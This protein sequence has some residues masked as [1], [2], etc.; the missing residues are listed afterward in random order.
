MKRR[1]HP[2]ARPRPAPSRES[3]DERQDGGLV[4]V[5]FTKR[6]QAVIPLRVD[7]A[8][9]HHVALAQL[10]DGGQQ[11]RPDP[12]L[13]PHL[14]GG[15]LVD[16]LHLPASRPAQEVEHPAA[17]EHL[18]LP[19]LLEGGD[20]E[21]RE[22]ADDHQHD[23]RASPSAC[24]TGS[25][26]WSTAKENRPHASSAR[27]TRRRLSSWSHAARSKESPG[28]EAA[29]RAGARRRCHRGLP[30]HGVS[31]CGEARGGE[32]PCDPSFSLGRLAGHLT[33]SRSPRASTV[34]VTRH[35]PSDE[36]VADAPSPHGSRR[37]AR[38]LQRTC[39]PSA[40]LGIGAHARLVGHLRHRG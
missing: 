17:G 21:P 24:W 11:Q 40:R 25:T 32:L 34:L 23:G 27:M 22:R 35:R 15:R 12:R 29:T 38:R 39:G 14:P 37:P 7:R 2:P 30:R 3:V 26:T 9:L 31:R 6:E 28:F 16:P 33:G 4:G 5:L 1:R 18:E 36:R 20:E 10:L 19:R 13:Q 8:Q